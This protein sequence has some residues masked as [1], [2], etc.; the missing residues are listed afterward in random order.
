MRVTFWGIGEAL[1][2]V[3]GHME[4]AWDILHVLCHAGPR[5]TVGHPCK[6]LE[7]MGRHDI[8]HMLE[9]EAEARTG[10]SPHPEAGK[11]TKIQ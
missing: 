10:S 5:C 1:G 8:I 2:R 3:V 9:I 7:R 4:G 11:H 6:A